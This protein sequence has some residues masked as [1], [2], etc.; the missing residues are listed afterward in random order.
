MIHPSRCVDCHSR[1]EEDS[2]VSLAYAT[3]ARILAPLRLTIRSREEFNG[4]TPKASDADGSSL[5]VAGEAD[6][7]G[8]L[9][10]ANK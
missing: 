3:Q 2:R 1:P 10:Q 8:G 6:C 9:A 7:W 4:T 5:S